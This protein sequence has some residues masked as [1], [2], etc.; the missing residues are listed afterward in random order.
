MQL[1]A[2]KIVPNTCERRQRS[3]SNVNYDGLSFVESQ[4]DGLSCTV[5][6]ISESGARLLLPDFF[7]FIP[8]KAKLYIEEKNILAECEQIWRNGDEIGVKF[9]SVVHID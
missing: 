8:R 5:L 1:L 9:T 7:S 4:P 6:N 3:R 2:A